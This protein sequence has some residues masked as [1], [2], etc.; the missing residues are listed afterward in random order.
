MKRVAVVTLAVAVLAVVFASTALAA[1]RPSD[2]AVAMYFHRT[3]RCPTCLKMGSYSE[4]AVK[5]GFAE[6]VKE[7]S[8]EFHYVDFQDKKNAALTKGYQ[9]SGPALI[10]AK[11]TEGKVAEF[12]DLK[13]IWTK[14]RE[15]D[16]FLKYVRENVEAYR[17]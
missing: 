7:G 15:K 12:K 5:K 6:Q 2:R 16:E 11:V 17:K 4:E 3:Q 8:V 13:D 10:V 1:D 9:V 14:V